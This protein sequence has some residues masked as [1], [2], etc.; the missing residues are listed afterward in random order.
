LIFE[1]PHQS[2]VSQS[3][4]SRAILVRFNQITIIR[5]N[6]GI[7]QPTTTTLSWCALVKL[8]QS[9]PIAGSAEVPKSL[10]VGALQPYSTD[11][12]QFRH[13]PTH[14]NDSLL[15]RFS[16]I[17]TIRTNRWFRGGAKVALC[18]CASAIFHR[19]API[20]GLAKFSKPRYLG[21]L[22]QYPADP[23][24]LQHHLTNHSDSLLVHFRHYPQIRIISKRI[25][26]GRTNLY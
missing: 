22:Q 19:S 12:H 9:A 21:A 4:Q 25:G 26:S 7:S 15:V 16:K 23:H 3:F 17:T 18:W 24:Q 20:V 2:P 5:T 10:S 6:F 11:P 1:D 8:L 13:Q 14:H